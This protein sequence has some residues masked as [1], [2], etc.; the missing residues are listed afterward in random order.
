MVKEIRIQS[1]EYFKT[2]KVET[3]ELL[4]KKKWQLDEVVKKI[5]SLEEKWIDN[6]I[7]KDAYSSWHADHSEIALLKIDGHKKGDHKVPSGGV[8]G[9]RTPVQT[10]PSKAFYMFI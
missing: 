7:R 10:Y 9:T 8:E 3:G 5:K 4:H 2:R 1:Q 6:T